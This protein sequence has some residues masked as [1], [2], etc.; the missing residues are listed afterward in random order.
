MWED[1]GKKKC[2]RNGLK[3][4]R[5][6]ALLWPQGTDSP[7]PPSRT[8]TRREPCSERSSGLYESCVWRLRK[9][10]IIGVRR[11]EEIAVHR[12]RGRS[13]NRVR[14]GAGL[15][16]ATARRT[17]LEP[18]HTRDSPRPDPPVRGPA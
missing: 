10:P 17:A 15:Q 12:L 2:L 6:G 7:S 9:S 5:L 13:M 11:T 18:D 3:K 16:T 8:R 4:C 1:E 14:A